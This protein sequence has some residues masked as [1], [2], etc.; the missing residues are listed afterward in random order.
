MN[1]SIPENAIHEQP[2][3]YASAVA[4]TLVRVMVLL[5]RRGAA[6]A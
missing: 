5:D 2:A 6:E 1:L 3:A 4:E